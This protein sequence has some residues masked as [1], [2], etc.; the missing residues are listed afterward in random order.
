MLSPR[1][2]I[3]SI[4][5]A[6]RVA[7]GHGSGECGSTRGVTKEDIRE[8]QYCNSELACRPDVCSHRHCTPSVIAGEI[9]CFCVNTKQKYLT[10]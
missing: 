1:V 10:M 2:Q 6:I 9:Q 5:K 8:A 3:C 4:W 7:K